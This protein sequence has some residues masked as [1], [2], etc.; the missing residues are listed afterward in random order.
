[1]S[2]P[3]PLGSTVTYAQWAREGKYG[4][5]VIPVSQADSGDWLGWSADG[6]M[7]DSGGQGGHGMIVDHRLPNGDFATMESWGSHGPGFNTRR[8]DFPTMA[9]RLD[10]VTPAHVERMRELTRL[11]VAQGITYYAGSG[12]ND[13]DGLPDRADL[14]DGNGVD[15]T[16]FNWDCWDYAFSGPPIEEDDMFSDQDRA[17]LAKVYAQLGDGA[18]PGILHDINEMLVRAW[19]ADPADS[20][21]GAFLRIADV[22]AMLGAIRDGI[23][24]IPSVR[25]GDTLSTLKEEVGK[26]VSRILGA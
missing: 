18:Q 4:L 3:V 16:G 6:N 14:N 26:I 21:S 12:D 22:Q 10:G 24:G 5:H 1:M 23:T 17:M 2:S 8:A 15:C 20:A 9:A 25:P 19:R 13:H 7:D 11:C